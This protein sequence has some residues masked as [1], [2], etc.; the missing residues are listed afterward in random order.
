M[1]ERENKAG[2]NGVITTQAVL[3]RSTVTFINQPTGTA[4]FPEK[5]VSLFEKAEIQGNRWNKKY[6][7]QLVVV[8][9][10]EK[11]AGYARTSTQFTLPIPP[12]QL[13]IDMPFAI[14]TSATLGGVVEEHNGAPFRM[15]SMSGTTGVLPLKGSA[16]VAQSLNPIQSVFAGTSQAIGRV[17][18]SVSKI[19][20][21]TEPNVVPDSEFEVIN[22]DINTT[23]GYYQFHLLRTFLENYANKKKTIEGRDF[24]LAL[25]LWKDNSVYLVTPTNFRLSRGVASPFEYQYSLQFKAFARI[26]LETTDYDQTHSP[27]GRDPGALAA[28]INKIDAARQVLSA[29]G[30][31]LSA[32]RSD[33]NNALFEPVR[34]VIL[35][36]KD[37]AGI[38]QKVIDLPA[39]IVIDTMKSTLETINSTSGISL[40][41]QWPNATID[42]LRQMLDLAVNSSISE[43]KS[44][45]MSGD[46]GQQFSDRTAISRSPNPIVSSYK[47]PNK[48]YGLLSSI[49]ISQLKLS[50]AIQQKINQEKFKARN[51]TR[52]DFENTRDSVLT[53][54]TDYADAVGLGNETYNNTFG[55]TTKQSTV[56]KVATDEDIE[57]L[58]HLNEMVLE[59]NKLCVSNKMDPARIDTLQFVAG[60]ASGSGI[61]FNVPASKYSVPYLYNHTLEQMA[62][63]YLGDPNRWIEIAT[64]NGLQE[65]YVDETGFD[66]DLLVNGYSNSIE[67]A[68]S[69]NLYIGQPVYI[70]SLT[71]N[72]ESRRITGIAKISES[73]WV[74]TLS[75]DGDLDRFKVADKSKI[76]AY[77]PNTVNSQMSIY[78]PSDEPTEEDD[79]KTKQI[80]G[81][82]YFDSLIRVGGISLLL[83]P[84]NDIVFD[85]NGSKLAVGLTNIVQKAKIALSTPRGALLH[86]KSYGLPVQVG[87]STADVSAQDILQA[88]QQMFEGDR[89]FSGVTGITVLKSGP[90]TQITANIGISGVQKN[91]P[92]SV[93]IQR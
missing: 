91:I 11:N 27:I 24:R 30:N 3:N 80:E 8:K 33:I 4:R 6:P 57:L 37:I 39:N 31:V 68:D 60:L 67:V 23:S 84:T 93:N 15:I 44:G 89:T 81:V 47:N 55:I 86:H 17:A 48:I 25:C 46:E 75:G 90:S 34:Q 19:V 76:H 35:G 42:E 9:K 72:N 38:A 32:V 43:T 65:P 51:Q 49:D 82:D 83:S 12:Q 71:E 74:I 58:F 28:I 13:D 73:Q 1:S 52:K 14:T 20:N 41:T 92:I 87:Q 63:K 69:S 26:N 78:I 62:D 16:G 70:S 54:M 77:L 21:S 7:Y 5:D 59:L 50:P 22:S 29:S 66:I 18:S 64:L 40:Q 36:L 45:L 53:V 61:A 2:S 79:W 88:V 85:S 56:N 10:L